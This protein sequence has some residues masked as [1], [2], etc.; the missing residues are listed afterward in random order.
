MSVYSLIQ[1]LIK[2]HSTASI[3]TNIEQN[4]ADVMT[5]VYI[6]NKES[7]DILI[8]NTGGATPSQKRNTLS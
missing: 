2:N 5:L 3:W 7:G 4:H 1:P 8:R 6:D